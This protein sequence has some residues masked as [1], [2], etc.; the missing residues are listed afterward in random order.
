[1]IKL[2]Q[3]IL[4]LSPDSYQELETSFKKTKADN[5][6]LLFKAYRNGDMADNEIIDKLG[7]SANSFYVLKSRL[8]DKIQEHFSVDIFSDRETLVKELL[9]VHEIC[10]TKPRETAIAFLHKLGKELLKYDLHNDLL[11]VYRAL[12]KMN[13]CSEKYFHY[14]Q[15]FNKHAGLGLSL[16]KAEEIL[17]NFNRMLG[18][19]NFSRSQP[20]LDSLLFLKLEI[21]NLYALNSS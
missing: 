16:E 15:L 4:Q 6:E 9:Q 11:V 17:G 21:T 12:K 7:I 13:M 18:L 3:V 2:K 1:M 10:F 8:Y 19:Y 20:V 14:S 5:F